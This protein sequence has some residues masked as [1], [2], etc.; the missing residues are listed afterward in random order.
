MLNLIIDSVNRRLIVYKKFNAAHQKTNYKI[1]V[2]KI[3]L[4]KIEKKLFSFDEYHK[5]MLF[6]AKLIS[7]LKNKLFI[8]KD[9][10]SIKEIILFKII[11]QEITFNRTRDDD[12]YNHS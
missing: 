8:I 7:V 5:A 11:M 4:E 1:S 6:L 2:F 9:V 3:Y 12:D 10:L